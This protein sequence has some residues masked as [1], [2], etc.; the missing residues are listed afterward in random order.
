MPIMPSKAIHAERGQK[1]EGEIPFSGSGRVIGARKE[2]T[3]NKILPI[4]D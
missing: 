1:T 4:A 3:K 2:K